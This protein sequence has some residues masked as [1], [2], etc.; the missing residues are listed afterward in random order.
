MASEPASKTYVVMEYD[1]SSTCVVGVVAGPPGL[2]ISSLYALW[3]R[4]AWK[5]WRRI[6][7]R[8][9]AAGYEGDTEWDCFIS[10]LVKDHGCSKVDYEECGI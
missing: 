5:E 7:P 8:M 1:Y 9:N 4:M 3:S 6:V 2:E 10:H